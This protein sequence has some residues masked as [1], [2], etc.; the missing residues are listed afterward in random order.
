M[1]ETQEVF[2][3]IKELQKKQINMIRFEVSAIAE[4]K[5]RLT[6]RDI[7]KIPAIEKERA[8][9]EKAQLSRLMEGIPITNVPGA[10]W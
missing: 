3:Y 7:C 5:G 2:N 4:A 10:L 9:I 6:W 1:Q 8:N